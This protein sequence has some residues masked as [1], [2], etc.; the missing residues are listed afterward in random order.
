MIAL[1]LLFTCA[2]GWLL[3]R[4]WL[5]SGPVVALC[6]SF[7]AGAAALSLQLLLYDLAR[8]PWHRWTLLAPWVLGGAAYLY[9]RRPHLARP[10]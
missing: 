4:P 9:R 1:A 3:L 7:T 8:I 6:L 10:Q 2:A 5:R